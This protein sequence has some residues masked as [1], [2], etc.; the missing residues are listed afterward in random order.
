MAFAFAFAFALAAS[1]SDPAS[2]SEL[3]SSLIDN[4][5]GAADFYYYR[6]RR[7][8]SP[9]DDWLF[10]VTADDIPAPV[11]AVTPVTPAAPTNAPV[12][13]SNSNGKK[14]KK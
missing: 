10:F 7:S 2:L 1:S 4:G 6:P 11:A 9:D 13:L 14:K 5:Q 3:A 12:D 8:T